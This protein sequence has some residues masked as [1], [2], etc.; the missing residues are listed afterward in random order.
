MFNCHSTLALLGYF[1]FNQC[2]IRLEAECYCKLRHLELHAYAQ[3]IQTRLCFQFDTVYDFPSMSLNCHWT[4]NHTPLKHAALDKTTSPKF[5]DICRHF[6]LCCLTTPTACTKDLLQQCSESLVVFGS[7]EWKDLLVVDGVVAKVVN[8]GE[9]RLDLPFGS[10]AIDVVIDVDV[11][12]RKELVN[13]LR[14]YHKTICCSRITF[15]H[16][17]MDWG[18]GVSGAISAQRICQASKFEA[19][20]WP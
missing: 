6:H 13:V 1:P 7:L 18:T 19:V 3:P 20:R 11:D 15:L 8:V 2:T 5:L 9:N 4:C 14:I 16:C 17:V 10:F 12:F